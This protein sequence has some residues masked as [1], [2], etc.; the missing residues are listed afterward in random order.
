MLLPPGRKTVEQAELV[1]R[2]LIKRH[3]MLVLA[4]LLGEC[5]HA[6]V[7]PFVT[8]DLR[9]PLGLLLVVMLRTRA[10]RR[11]SGGIMVARMWLLLLVIV[12]NVTG[13]K[14]CGRAQVCWG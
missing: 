3:L 5:T 6:L 7:D 12:I 13:R 8:V 1:L 10:T 9:S 11:E 14:R 2:H 4:A